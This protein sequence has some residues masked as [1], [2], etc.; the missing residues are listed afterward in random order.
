MLPHPSYA[1]GVA[2][3]VAEANFRAEIT[4]LGWRL[5]YWPKS[6]TDTWICRNCG[7]QH[8]PPAAGRPDE[9]WRHPYWPSIPIEVK[10]FNRPRKKFR[11]EAASFPF[12]HLE[13][14]QRV[15]LTMWESE[16][17]HTDNPCLERSGSYLALGTRHGRAGARHEPRLGWLIPWWYWRTQV[18]E[19]I[20]AVGQESLPL[21]AANARDVAMREY[22]ADTLLQAYKLEWDN[23]CWHL[24]ELHPLADLEQLTDYFKERWAQLERSYGID[25]T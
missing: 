15:W 24:P 2:I 8:H 14:E 3:L 10:M 23:G 18:E 21:V 25:A 13:P 7:Q 22:G 9:V 4:N 11:W 16:T 5:R 19:P 20:R 17:L 6:E 1:K 12:A